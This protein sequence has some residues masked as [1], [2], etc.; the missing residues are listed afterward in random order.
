MTLEELL[1][2]G[3][4]MGALRGVGVEPE[5]A[6]RQAIERAVA[7]GSLLRIVISD[8]RGEAAYLFLNTPQGRQAVAEVRSGELL[9]ERTGPV[10]EPHLGDLRPNIFRLYEDN[11]GLLTPMLAEE[12]TLATDQYPEAWLEDAVRIAVEHNVRNWR[13]VRSILERWEREGR[14]GASAPRHKRRT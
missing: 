7:R 11:I 8:D 12:L 2:E 4:L 10:H 5:A 14:D 6:L 1:A 3:C 9:L 13:Y